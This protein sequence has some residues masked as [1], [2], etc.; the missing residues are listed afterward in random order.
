M[1]EIV[2]P[3]VHNDSTESV[4]DYSKAD[5]G[6]MRELLSDLDWYEELGG[7]GTEDSWNKFKAKLN[8]VVDDC[9][10][11]KI[12]RSGDKKPLWMQQNVLR[13]IRKKRRVWDWYQR[14]RE[15]ESGK[16]TSKYRMKL[17]KR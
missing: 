16:P 5:Y 10:P 1:A 8:K 3:Q 17:R 6:R 9:V 11:K 12:R 7:L 15:Y 13:L 2:L 4:P 14:T